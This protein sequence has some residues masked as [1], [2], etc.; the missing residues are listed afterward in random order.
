MP[1]EKL[2]RIKELVKKL[3]EAA[4]VYYDE[5]KEIMS[6]YEYDALYDELEQLENE[7]G[8]VLPDSPTRQVG[9]KA[10][11]E[12]VKERHQNPMLSLG[13]TKSIDELA[14]FIKGLKGLLSWKMDG[15]TIVL[16]YEG[17]MLKKA[18]TRGDGDIG[19]VVT[20]NA[21]AFKNLPESIPFKGKLVVRG[22]AV[23]KYSDFERINEQQPDTDAQYKNPRNLCSGSVR[24]S[25]PSVTASRCVNLYVFSLE[26]AEYNDEGGSEKEVDFDDS[27]EKRFIWLKGQGFDVVEYDAVD[28]NSVKDSVLGFSK[29]I[30]TYDIPSDGLVLLMDSISYGKSLGR[31]AKFPR[32]AIAFKWQDE[33]MQTTL[34]DIEWSPS[35][36]GLINPIAIFDPIELVGTTVSRASLHNLSIVKSLKLG[37]GDTITVYKANMI[38]PQIAENLTESDSAQ[39]PE[40]CPACHSRTVIEN[41]QG[42]MTVRCPNELCPTKKIKS[43]AN[44]VSRDCMNIE[45]I[46]EKILEKFIDRGFI[47][48]FSDLYHLD[49]YKDDI[50]NMQ[51]FGIRSYERIIESV[52]RSRSTTPSR[53]LCALGISGIGRENANLISRYF[54]GDFEKISSAGYDELLETQGIGD[55]I[56]RAFVSFFE[57][58]DNR[59]LVGRIL[60]EI[61]FESDDDHSDES[62]TGLTFV[63]T[64]ELK[65]YPN[66][67][68]LKDEIESK[69]GK[70][71]GSV[72]SKTSYLINND[73]SSG[74]SKNKTAMKLG[75]PIISEQDYIERFR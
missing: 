28:E 62:L 48:D 40:F 60:N 15:L 14:H 45:G 51:G 5:N 59:A 43:F 75:I 26:S 30:E 32:N 17:G 70:V 56:A 11:N 64:G 68:A 61:T 39:A 21:K 36:T 33:I 73:I 6:N 2:K 25:D 24:Q 7:S 46:S 34:R 41:E 54:K 10:A 63:I 23:I 42:I 37:I 65:Q 22:E 50:I 13:K 52:N 18:V 72:S 27:N 71:A 53:L 8:I 67:N 4:K 66:R 38:I 55:I 3:N 35:R 47:G 58:E 20:E 49:R 69:G 29:K 12:L 9:Y 74:S 31:T 44:Y 1:E 16:T 19:E 57:D